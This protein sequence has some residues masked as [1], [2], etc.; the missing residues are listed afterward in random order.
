M[1]AVKKR[2]PG[3]NKKGAKQIERIATAEEL[4]VINNRESA[5]SILK[6]AKFI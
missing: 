1:L 2:K 6:L 3:W 4:A 5:E